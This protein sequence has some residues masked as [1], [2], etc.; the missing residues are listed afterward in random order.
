MINIGI[1]A[2]AKG[3]SLLLYVLLTL[4]LWF[5]ARELMTFLVDDL[6]KI[7][8]LSDWLHGSIIAS[9]PVLLCLGL[10]RF[11]NSRK[12]PDNPSKELES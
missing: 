2:K 9:L 5:G 10:F 12:E 7:E 1:E 6:F 4:G 8:G 3:R 11:I